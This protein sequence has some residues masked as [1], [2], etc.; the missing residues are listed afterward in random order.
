MDVV[1]DLVRLGDSGLQS[2]GRLS[3]V[4]EWGRRDWGWRLNSGCMNAWVHRCSLVVG[5]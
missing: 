2:L 4:Y 5:S 3:R 1:L